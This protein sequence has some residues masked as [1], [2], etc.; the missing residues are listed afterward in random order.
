MVKQSGLQIEEIER[1]GG[2]DEEPA[3]GRQCSE[4]AEARAQRTAGGKELGLGASMV[5]EVQGM[6]RY[7]G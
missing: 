7:W 2:G 6:V 1:V 3:P 4:A 5:V